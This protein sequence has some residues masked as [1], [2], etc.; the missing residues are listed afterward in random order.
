MSTSI[1][2]FPSIGSVSELQTQIHSRGLIALVPTAELQKEM[3]L[4]EHI[5]PFIDLVNQVTTTAQELH[6]GID[7]E[8]LLY[9][10]HNDSLGRP[11]MYIGYNVSQFSNEQIEMIRTGQ[12]PWRNDG[13]TLIVWSELFCIYQPGKIRRYA[14]NG[15]EPV[16]P[17]L[18][19][20]IG[21]ISSTLAKQSKS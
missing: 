11:E 10:I 13:S 1:K 2:E 15:T 17:A 7:P 9:E 4:R 20:F 14:G 12:T 21:N 19:G 3:S 6:Q 5:M 8:K 18:E 16:K